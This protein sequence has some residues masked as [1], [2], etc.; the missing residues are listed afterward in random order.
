MENDL[1]RVGGKG[2]ILCG[3]GACVSDEQ[4]R[5]TLIANGYTTV[6]GDALTGGEVD[7]QGRATIFKSS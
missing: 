5:A 6:E 2:S 1:T 4:H 7:G 3:R